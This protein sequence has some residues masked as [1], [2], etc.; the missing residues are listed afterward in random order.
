MPFISVSFIFVPL[1]LISLTYNHS[2]FSS[3]D[4]PTPLCFPPFLYMKFHLYFYL[5]FLVTFHSFVFSRHCRLFSFIF[6]FSCLIQSRLFLWLSTSTLYLYL[7]SSLPS[8]LPF[9]FI[10]LSNRSFSKQACIL[11][12]LSCPLCT[13]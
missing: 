5:I 3:S 11:S 1:P 2:H 7:Y 10:P 4:C 13:G 8:F 6:P 12:S 9:V